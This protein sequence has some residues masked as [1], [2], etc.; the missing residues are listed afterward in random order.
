VVF[1][2]RGDGKE[3]FRSPTIRD[4]RV[5][6][7]TIVVADVDVLELLVENGG[8]GNAGDW[9]VWLSPGLAR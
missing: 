7:V 4:H 3:L 2:I 8:D 9:G 1:V 6:E 5:R